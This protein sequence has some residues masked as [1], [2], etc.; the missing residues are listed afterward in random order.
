MPR[1]IRQEIR[2]Q[3]QN[4]VGFFDAIHGVQVSTEGELAS[5]ARAVANRRL[6]L[7]PFRFRIQLQQRLQL[8]SHRR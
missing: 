1:P 4:H 5:L 7:M 3:R 2:I 8:R 6:P